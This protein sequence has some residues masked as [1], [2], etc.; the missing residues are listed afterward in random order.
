MSMTKADFDKKLSSVKKRGQK[1]GTE[2]RHL[3][4][5]GVMLYYGETNRNIQVINDLVDCAN[6]IKGLRVKGLVEYL[7]KVI[8]HE[9]L[10]RKG[11][12]H[13]GKM[14]K[15][16][17]D[18]M[19]SSWQSFL[20]ENPNWD[21]FSEEKD[22]APFSLEQFLKSVSRRLNKA[23][24]EGQLGKEELKEF[25]KAITDFDFTDEEA[26]AEIKNGTSPL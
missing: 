12:H 14:D 4:T 19:D 9:N 1:V 10:G 17:K 15:N 16:L 24:K 21:E 26:E 13:F 11:D 5:Q 18:Q 2:F 7:T 22:P 25:K 8:P 6:A 3:V 23:H 20:A